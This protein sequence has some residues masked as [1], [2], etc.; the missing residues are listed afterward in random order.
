MRK[1]IASAGVVL[2]FI[3]L[4][5]A[6]SGGAQQSSPPASAQTDNESCTEAPNE[7]VASQADAD[8]SAT[9]V[10]MGG[11]SD[12]E[13]ERRKQVCETDWENCYDECTRFYAN[14]RGWSKLPACQKI[15]VDK[16]AECMAK[17]P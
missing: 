11:M 15:C 6:A 2:F 16:L 8:D 3:L 13:K 7:G 4:G 5:S 9:P 1:F 14:K 17:I 12:A 10:P